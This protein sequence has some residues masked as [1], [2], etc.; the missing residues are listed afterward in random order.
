M[1]N[2][3]SKGTHFKGKIPINHFLLSTRVVTAILLF[4]CFLYST[5][6]A[7]TQQQKK[8][9][10]GAVMDESGT[11]I[12]GANVIEVGTTNGTVTDIDGRFGR[13]VEQ[14]ASMNI[15]YFS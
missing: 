7:G 5:V 10:T 8:Q 2:Y 6:E 12:I 15:S 13:N 1:I 9:I 4:T 3:K 14:N 11:P